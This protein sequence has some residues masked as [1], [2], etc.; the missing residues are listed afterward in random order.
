MLNAQELAT[1]PTADTNVLFD[2]QNNRFFLEPK[3][4]GK[5]SCQ[6][7]ILAD[8]MGMGMLFYFLYLFYKVKP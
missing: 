8:E 2:L 3:K 6:G 1:W 7:G 5:M 4:T